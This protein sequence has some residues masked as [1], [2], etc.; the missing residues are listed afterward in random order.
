LLAQVN[1]VLESLDAAGHVAEFAQQ[2]GLTY[3]AP[4]EPAVL[5]RIAPHMLDRD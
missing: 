4:R 3:V 1:R 5:D 2:V